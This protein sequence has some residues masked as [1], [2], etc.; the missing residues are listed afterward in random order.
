MVNVELTKNKSL[1]LDYWD[2]N[3]AGCI[4]SIDYNE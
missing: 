3:T 1:L 4:R 2:N